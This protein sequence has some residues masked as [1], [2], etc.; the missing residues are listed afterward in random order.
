MERFLLIAQHV[1]VWVFALFFGLLLLGSLQTRSREVSHIQALAL[2][3]AMI[4]YSFYGI[5]STFG[6]HISVI[7]YWLGG[8]VSAVGFNAYYR[9]P[10]DAGYDAETK[11]FQIPGS[12]I[13]LA[14]IM[15]IF[16]TKFFLGLA[17]ARHLAMLNDPGTI[18]SVSVLLG[19]FSGMFLASGWV[20]WRIKKFLVL[21]K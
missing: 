18:A 13:P 20:L 16:F 7:A 14:L 15:G 11:R 9:Y 4:L 21:N 6:L 17:K 10:K 3:G 5:V 19:F 1:P 12:Y 8:V 2:P